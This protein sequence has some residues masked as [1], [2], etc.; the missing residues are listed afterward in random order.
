MLVAFSAPAWVGFVPVSAAENRN[1]VAVVI[2]NKNYR[3]EVPA[4]DFALND[5]DAMKR[6]VVERLGY[7]P[8]NVIDLRDASKGTIETVFGTEETHKGRLYNWV[9]PGESDIVVYY[10]GH[11]MPSLSDQRSYLLPVDADPNFVEIG[12]YPLDLLYR[13]LERLQARSVTIYLDACFS[14]ASHKGMLVEHLSAILIMPRRPEVTAKLTILTAADGRQVASWDT[15]VQHGLFTHHLL[16]AL[17]GAADKAEF[18][19]DDGRVTLGEVKNFLDGEMTYQA[20][21]R[22]NRQ[23]TASVLGDPKRVLA[24]VRPLPEKQ[25]ATI[26][27]NADEEVAFWRSIRDSGDAAKYRDYLARYP[28]GLFA[29]VARLRLG[30][31]EGTASGDSDQERRVAIIKSALTSKSWY[32]QGRGSAPYWHRFEFSADGGVYREW[33]GSSPSSGSGRWSLEADKRLCIRWSN[34]SEECFTI[35][36]DGNE[37]GLV[38]KLG[39]VDLS[40]YR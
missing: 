26:D 25:I 37:I 20:R 35:S 5:A 30:N 23:Q 32:R 34:S 28:G 12:G 9:R 11:G 24:V 29:E 8:G 21:R 7:R 40:L 18:G 17:N 13:N 39:G 14:G 4:V 36:I 22:Y 31:D 10:S 3:G 1:G 19:N 27:T 15:R 16:R 33:Q 2:G 38:R 6:F